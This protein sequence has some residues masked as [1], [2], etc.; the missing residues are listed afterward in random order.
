MLAQDKARVEKRH[1]RVGQTLV[2]L[3]QGA[4]DVVQNAMLHDLG[5]A[6]TEDLQQP[7]HFVG[8]VIVFLRSGLRVLR[9]AR[10]PCAT[11]LFM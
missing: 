1:Q 10:T 7:A 3:D 5:Q 2:H 6:D 8:K 4:D 11:R 9:N